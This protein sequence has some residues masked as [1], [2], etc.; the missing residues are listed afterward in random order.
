MAEPP[1]TPLRFERLSPPEQLRRV[2]EYH[3]RMVARRS[4]RHF[5][6]EPVDLELIAWA[7]RAA[8]RAPSGANLQPWHF[9]VVSDRETKKKIR[10]VAEVEE[11]DNYERRFP[12][13]WKDRLRPLGTTW[14]KK[15][16]ETAPCLIVV[17]AAVRGPAFARAGPGEAVKHYYVSESVGIAT[18]FLLS[19]LHLAGL[20]TLTHTPSPMRF[21]RRILRRPTHEKAYMIIPVGYPAPGAVVPR[22]GKKPLEEIVT[23]WDGRDR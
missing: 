9:V 13:E 23:W 16:L 14:E 21:L 17:F 5:S 4:V 19:A 18:G 11:K 22:I 8:G 2:R 7:I 10:E 3:D 20:A 1:F 15:F 6:D 12:A